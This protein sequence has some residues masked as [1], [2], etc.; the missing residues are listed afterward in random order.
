MHWRTSKTNIDYWEMLS[1]SIATSKSRRVTTIHHHGIDKEYNKGGCLDD[2]L[3]M[4][5]LR[6]L[7][8]SWVSNQKTKVLTNSIPC[9][10]ATLCAFHPCHMLR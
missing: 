8:N 7:Y 5:L 3:M 2:N 6:D 9:D 1:S 10:V 4:C